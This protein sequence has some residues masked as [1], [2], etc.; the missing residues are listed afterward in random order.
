MIQ[1]IVSV[2]L[3]ILLKFLAH[4]NFIFTDGLG[5]LAW[6]Y[7]V[8]VLFSISKFT[9]KQSLISGFIYG[10]FSYGFTFYWLL[11]YD[12]LAGLGAYL[13]FGIYWLVIFVFLKISSKTRKYS[14]IFNCA[15]IFL[16]EFFFSAGYFGFTYGVS[17]YTQ[18]KYSLFVRS[19]RYLKVWGI[20]FLIVYFNCVLAAI[21]EYFY[22]YRHFN[23][24]HCGAAIFFG[25]LLFQY[26]FVGFFLDEEKT[27][28][29]LK[30][31]LIQSNSDPW[32]DGINEYIKEVES[33]KELTDRA[34]LENPGTEL[35]VWPESAV[36][37][38]V[39]SYFIYRHNS[40]VN[41]KRVKLATELF[42]YIN[43]KNCRFL[44]GT[45]FKHF[46]SAV[47]FTPT[48]SVIESQ[49][50]ILPNW[51]V[52]KKNH[53]VPVS[54]DFPFKGLL[55]KYYKESVQ[56]GRYWLPGKK[57]RLLNCGNVTLGTPVCF[58]DTFG[59]ISNAMC[60]K[61]AELLV[62]ISNDSW[63]ASRACQMQHMAVACF[64]AIENGVPF[65]RATNSGETCFINSYGT[66]EKRIEPFK[67]D[68]LYC[69]VE[70]NRLR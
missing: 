64:R 59:N 3:S 69:E 42:D 29:T 57:M 25:L 30:V 6:I 18:W 47:L 66:V 65:L 16:A 68:W 24:V 70:L 23:Y 31:A 34:L 55:N 11:K 8:P 14:F 15:L 53:L 50:T 28:K 2:F 36:V 43:S 58:E 62:N 22:K 26:T 37:V 7:Y 27:G 21:L 35:V 48:K 40:Q 67:A 38:D 44:I 17:G 61:G 20:T 32:K 19:A 60:D 52:Y 49:R 4:P 33:L 46:N 41:Q 56:N 12:I 5:F 13:L 39:I 9:I 54:E 10:F 1:C 51:Q 45:N 63:C